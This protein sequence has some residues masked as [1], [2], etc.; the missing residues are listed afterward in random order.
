[1]F[2]ITWK[3]LFLALALSCPALAATVKYVE[4]R[5]TGTLQP[6]TTNGINISSGTILVFNAST[7]TV[8]GPLQMRDGNSSDLS[9]YFTNDTDLGWYRIGGNNIGWL[10]S[11][12][13]IFRFV[14]S[15]SGNAFRFNKARGTVTSTTTVSSGDTIVDWIG[16]G[17]DGASFQDAVKVEMS[18][19]TTP[20]IGDMPGRYS[21]YTSS[22][23]GVT[24]I[25]AV[26]IDRNQQVRGVDGTKTNPTHSFIL[27]PDSGYYSHAT[28]GT[29]IAG[30]GADYIT[31][32]STG[33]S[34]K[35]GFLE[36]NNQTLAQIK[37][38]TP[39][40]IG[41]Q[42]NCSDCTVTPVCISTG[43]GIFGFSGIASRTTVCQ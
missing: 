28:N 9:A 22:D 8:T 41:L 4:I 40:K 35:T 14:T 17:Y 20:G 36:L 5:P 31:F 33:V 29:A 42:Y 43:T 39:T 27:D 23:G 38:L 32:L 16:R 15:A 30:G 12:L 2:K 34:V 13:D 19:D 6:G 18:I 37:A 21:V 24:L 10:F 7:V 11:T 26:R 25:E 3:A 1:M